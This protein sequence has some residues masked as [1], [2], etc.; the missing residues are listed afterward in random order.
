MP[1]HI[2]PALGLYWYADVDP[3]VSPG[4]D[5]PLWQLLVRTDSPSIYYKAGFDPTDWVL[6]GSSAAPPT[7]GTQQVFAYQVDGTE[8]DRSNIVIPLPAARADALYQVQITQSTAANYLG[9]KIQAASR[10]TT[11]FVMSLTANATVGDIFW[12]T[13]ANPT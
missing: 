2:E 12:F 10:T 5:A 7:P 3:T 1:S 9:P 6:I 11:E 8:A 4:V 13:V